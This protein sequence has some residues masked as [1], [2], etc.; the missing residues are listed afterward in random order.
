MK[1]MGVLLVFLTGVGCGMLGY[2]NLKRRADALGQL[3]SFCEQLAERIR[4]TAAPLEDV[5]YALSKTAEFERFSLLRRLPPSSEDPR[6]ALLQAMTQGAEEM[7]LSADDCGVFRDFIA[8][9][10]AADWDGEVTR[11]RR[12]AAVFRQRYT[13][14][15][16]DLR[17]RGRVSVTLGCC[18]GGTLALV[19]G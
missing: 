14:A 18:V 8:D 19:L 17:R 10:G 13:E 5:V 4:Y 1:W 11:C 2:L 3:A 12:Y 16:E 9:F 15:R 6:A 7:G